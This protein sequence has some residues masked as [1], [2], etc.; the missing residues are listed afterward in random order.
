M[1]TVNICSTNRTCS[2]VRCEGHSKQQWWL[3]KDRNCVTLQLGVATVRYSTTHLIAVSLTGCCYRTVQHYTSN[4]SVTNWV[5][6]PYGTALH[7]YC[8]VT[9]ST[10]NG[11]FRDSGLTSPEGSSFSKIIKKFIAWKTYKMYFHL[12][13]QPKYSLPCPRVVTNFPTFTKITCRS[14]V[15]FLVQIWQ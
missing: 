13:P 11:T 6:L 12:R 14:L 8:S 15:L 1:Q 2:T 7:I 10:R 3:Q 4:C 5:L 9:N